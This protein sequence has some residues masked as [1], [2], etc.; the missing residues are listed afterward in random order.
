MKRI[1]LSLIIVSVAIA[2]HA[3]INLRPG[4]IITNENDSIYGSIDFRT[5]ERNSQ[6]CVF[7][8]NL[9]GETKTFLPGE[10]YAYRFTDDG[11]FYVSRTVIINQLEYKFFLEYII[12]GIISLYYLG[13]E[14]PHYFF[15]TE[16][17]QTVEVSHK[18]EMIEQKDGGRAYKKDN[19]YIGVLNYLFSDSEKAKKKI[20]Q[21][22]FSRNDFVKL[23]KEYHYDVCETGEECIEFEAKR[24]PHYVKIK[25]TA[26]AGAKIYTYDLWRPQNM[27]LKSAS[28][29]IGAEVDFSIPRLTRVIS[30]QIA[31]EGSKFS[32]EKLM[33][34]A[35]GKFNVLKG[36]STVLD[37]KIGLKIVPFAGKVMPF[38][39]GGFC[40]LFLISPDLKVS[41]ERINYS[42]VIETSETTYNGIT[43]KSYKGYYVN[44][45]LL[46][47]LNKKHVI[48]ITGGYQHNS[49]AYY[50]IDTWSMGLG[51]TF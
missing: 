4:Y 38:V 40:Q 43:P 23:T 45:G 51:F 1:I 37:G 49:H 44:A 26:R 42:N 12:Q 17:G 25:F 50:S 41:H 36:K 47:N 6:Q 30:V 24:D 28:P 48:S 7:K 10:I 14:F 35:N 22:T 34:F 11:R 3:Q 20:P 16:D 46:V 27:E 21:A 29:Y 18:E 39:G 13:G 33:G 2:I 8:D 15:E 31:L 9:T 32:A 5:G 19:R